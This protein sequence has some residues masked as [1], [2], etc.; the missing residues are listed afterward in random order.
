MTANKSKTMA[1]AMKFLAGDTAWAPRC[2]AGR[3]AGSAGPRRRNAQLRWAMRGLDPLLLLRGIQLG[4]AASEEVVVRVD[5]LVTGFQRVD[6]DDSQRLLIGLRA[7]EDLARGRD[8][9]TVSNVGQP[10]LP[11]A[12]FPASPVARH[13][14]DAVFQAARDH[15][16]GAVGQHQVGGM[17]DDVRTLQ[18]QRARR[19]GVEPIE[20]DHQPD[21]RRSDVEHGKS[22]VAGRK[23]Q[24]LFE[25]EVR[26]PVDA[27][28]SAWPH[29][30]CR[31]EKPISR[32][33]RQAGDDMRPPL[34]GE[35][36]QPLSGRASRNFLSQGSH[37]INRDELITGVKQ[38][39]QDHQI[40]FHRRQ[41]V[42]HRREVT[43]DVAEDR[44]KL[45][46]ANL[47][48]SILSGYSKRPA[49]EAAGRRAPRGVLYMYVEGFD[50]YPLPGFVQWVMRTKLG[51]SFSILHK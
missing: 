44:G 40:A 11:A 33:L 39:R 17:G 41:A 30:D 34:G 16:V 51:A 49:N 46:I 24:V 22:R 28:Q 18:G 8:D 6:L 14:E 1:V 7:P 38:L 45:E 12:L 20:A 26:L 2:S 15:G 13:R 36:P 27:D 5:F 50:G 32:P 3:T 4:P 35:L 31:I 37:L 21:P 42:R 9:F 47:H 29:Q 10:L 25:E 23:E 48:M 43:C 19:L